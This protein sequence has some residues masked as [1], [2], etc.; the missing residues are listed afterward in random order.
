MISVCSQV[1]SCDITVFQV[2]APT[3]SAEEVERFYD[4]LQDHPQ[5]KEHP[6]KKKKMKKGKMVV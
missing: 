2:Y 4:D 5:D 3:S 6:Q 1:K